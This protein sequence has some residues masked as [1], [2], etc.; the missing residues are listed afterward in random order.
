[1]TIEQAIEN[2]ISRLANTNFKD[3]VSEEQRQRILEKLGE[4]EAIINE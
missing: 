1:M 2:A 3:W 4:A